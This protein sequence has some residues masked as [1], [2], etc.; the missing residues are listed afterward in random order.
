MGV[1]HLLSDTDSQRGHDAR[2]QTAVV[3]GKVSKIECDDKRANVRVLLPDRIDHEGTPLNTKPIPVL[4]VA[5]TAKRSYAIP[6]LNDQVVLIKLA[7]ATSDYLVVGTFYTTSNKPPVSDPLL[8]YTEWE[9]GHI[10][11]FDA[12]EGADVFLTQDFKGGWLGTYKKDVLLKTTDAAKFNVEADGDVLIKSANG[13]ITVQSPTGTV[14]IEQQTIKLL[15]SAEIEIT[16][17][18][19]KLNGHVIV[20]G[21]ITQTGVHVDSNGLHTGAAREELLARIE[22]L[23]ARVATLEART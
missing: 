8:D 14:T 13:N 3:I 23:E 21:A 15:G 20:V 17:P 6:R 19:I 16:A 22:Q 11:Q 5:S 2:F 1:K 18:T 9:G 12:N 7:N 4:Q 10:Q